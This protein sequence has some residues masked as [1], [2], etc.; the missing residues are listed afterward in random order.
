MATLAPRNETNRIATPIRMVRKRMASGRIDPRVPGGFGVGTLSVGTMLVEGRPPRQRE[1]A[2]Y[3]RR[4]CRNCG[5]V[6][7]HDTG[8]TATA[9]VMAGLVPAISLGMARC[10]PHRDRRNKSGDDIQMVLPGHLQRSAIRQASQR[11]WR[12]VQT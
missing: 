11:G 4:L 2:I 10:P 6:W 3:Q 8:G 12:A 9:F 1:P 5:H 7:G